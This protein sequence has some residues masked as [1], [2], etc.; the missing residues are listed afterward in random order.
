MPKPNSFLIFRI[1]QVEDLTRIV[2]I[3]NSTIP[4]RMVTAD[5]QTLKV[6]DRKNWFHSHNPEKWPL[7]VAELGNQM[8]GYLGFEPFYNR[9]AYNY[10]A[11]ISVYLDEPF[12][13]KNLGM[14]FLD[15]AENQGKLLGF[16]TLMAFIFAHN[17]PSIKL[18][19]RSG[20]KE[21][22]LLPEIAILDGQKRSLKILGK[23]LV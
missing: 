10:T 13:G 21:W 2:E 14:L 22:A 12:R 8:V 19:E 6:E 18:F 1:A 3:Y 4:S 9:P 11:E 15:H 20:F 17:L 5:T 23:H 16:N 7:W